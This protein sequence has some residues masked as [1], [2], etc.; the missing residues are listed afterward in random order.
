MNASARTSVIIIDDHPLFRKGVADLI[1]MEPALHLKG[2]AADGESGI[3][4]AQDP[5]PDLILLDLNMK[6]MGGE[7]PG[8]AINKI[9]RFNRRS[10]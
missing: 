1:G 9:R 3:R 2:E 7:R 4:L 5:D 8:P 6:G 10:S